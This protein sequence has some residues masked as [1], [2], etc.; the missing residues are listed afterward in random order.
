MIFKL[1]E[2]FDNRPFTSD[3]QKYAYVTPDDLKKV[4]LPRFV[5]FEC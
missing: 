2:S 5:E 3:Y 4:P 1:Q